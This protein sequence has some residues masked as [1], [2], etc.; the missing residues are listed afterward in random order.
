MNVKLNRCSYGRTLLYRWTRGLTDF[1]TTAFLFTN[2]RGIK[3]LAKIELAAAP[4]RRWA[5]GKTRNGILIKEVVFTHDY[6]TNPRILFRQPHPSL[7][8][9]AVLDRRTNIPTEG[10]LN[11]YSNCRTL[12]YRRARCLTDVQIVVPLLQ[13]RGILT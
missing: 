7:Q 10:V 2:G 8:T 9:G 12:L 3:N 11:R 4:L 6:S 13:M 1:Q 5:R